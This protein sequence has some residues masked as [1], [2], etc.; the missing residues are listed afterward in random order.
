MRCRSDLHFGGIRMVAGTTSTVFV[1]EIHYDNAGGDV[2]EFIEIANTAGTDLTGWTLLLYN[3][4]NGLVYDTIALSGSDPFLTITFPANG[5][6]NGSPD[7]IAIV[8]ALGNVVQFLSYEGVMTAVDG[9]AAGLTSTDIGVAETTSTAVGFSLQLEGSGSTYGD[10]TWAAAAIAETPDAANTGQTIVPPFTPTTIFST[11]FDDFRGLGFA[12]EPVAGQLDSD[13]FRVLGMS[14]GNGSFGGTHTTGD[15]ARG[16]DV[17][18]GVSTGGVYA[19]EVGAASGDFNLGFQPGGSDVT[20]GS[21]DIVITNSGSDTNTFDISYN[22]EFNNNEGRANSLTLEYSTDGGATFVQVSA[23][24]F[25]TPEAADANGFTSV[26]RSGT[27]TLDTTISNGGSFILRFATDDVSGSGSRDEIAID[28]I[29][30]ITAAP[31]AAAS[32]GNF[33]INDVSLDEGDSG[34]T[35]FVF[36]VIRSGGSDGVATVDFS[37]SASSGSAVDASDFDGGVFPSGTVSFADGETAQ[38]ITIA[39]TGDIDIEADESFDVTLG[40]PTGGAT[41]ADDIGLGTI[42]NDDFPPPTPQGP[43]EVFINEIHYDNASGD[44]GEAIEIAGRA[45]TDLS[46]WQLVFYNG[47]GGVVYGTLDL[48]GV[49]PDQDD[50]YGTIGFSRS[51]LQNGSPDGLALVDPSGNVVQFLSYEGTMTATEGPAAGLTSDDIGVEEDG[52]T[53]AGFS[54]QLTGTGFIYDDFTWVS[55]REDNFGLV[56]TGQDF[57]PG[58]AAGTIIIQDA[59]VVEGDSG[60]TNL[61]FNVFRVGGTDGEVTVDFGTFFTG[62]FGAADPS[63]WAGQFGTSVTFAD[64]ESYQTVSIA[65]VGDTDGEPNET[66]EVRLSNPTGGAVIGDAVAIGTILND[67][68]VD[69][70][71]SEI[72]GAGH[73]SIWEGNEVTTTGVVTAVAANGFYMQDPLGDADAATSDA[74]FVFTGATPTV[75]VGDGLTVTGTVTEFLA[76][77]DSSNLTI[78]ELTNPVISVDS[79]GNPLPAAVVIGP[80]GISPPTEVIEDDGFTSFDPLTDGIDFWESLEGMLVTIQNPVAVDSTSGFGELWTAASDGEGNLVATNV[81]AEGLLVIDG[82]EGGLGVFNQGAGSDFNPERIQIDVAGELNGVEFIIPDVGPGARLNDVTGIVDYSFGNYEVRP[83]QAVTVAETSTSIAEAT[84]LVPGAQNQLSVASYNV[85]NFDINPDDGDD[86][87]GDGRLA[88][89]AYDIGVGLAAPDI[90]VLEEVQD[91]SGAIN[92]GTVS[93]TAT[94]QALAD[95]IFAETGIVYSVFDNP[96]VVDG[97]TGGQP[98][99]NIRVAFLYRDDRVDLDEASAFT[100]TD[101]E[102]GELDAAFAGSRAPLGANFTFNGETVTIIGSHFTSKIGSDNTFSGNQPPANAGALARAAQAAAIN[103]YIDGLLALD[104]DA[105]IALAGDF[106]EFHFEEPLEVLTG[107]LDFDGGSVSAG[108]S[109]VLENLTYLLDPSDRYSVLFQGNAQMLDHIL[110]TS[111]LAEGAAFDAVHLNT[112][113]GLP[114]SDH[115]PLLAI[116]NVGTQVVRGGRGGFDGNDGNDIIT[117]GT[118]SDVIN[119]NGGNDQ[120]NAGIGNDTVF[121]GSGR[122]QIEGGNGADEL[123]GEAGDDVIRGGNDADLINGG[124]DNDQLFGDNGDDQLFGGFGNDALSGGNGVDRLDGGFGLDTLFGG[125][126][127]DVFVLHADQTAADADVILDL[128]R[129]DSIEIENVDGREIELVASGNDTLITADGVLVARVIGVDPFT[130]EPA[131][132]GQTITVTTLSPTYGANGKPVTTETVVMR[133]DPEDKQAGAPEPLHELRG[134]STFD[135]VP[136]FDSAYGASE[137]ADSSSVAR[138]INSDGFDMLEAVIAPELDDFLAGLG[139][140]PGAGE[141][142]SAGV[143]PWMNGL[144]ANEVELV[145]FDAPAKPWLDDFSN[146]LEGLV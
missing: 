66:L 139:A 67:D 70:R 37:V 63:D 104:P 138:W 20:P 31:V 128:R 40:N 109:V 114:G 146:G 127:G 21:L 60:I 77:G 79:T 23:F 86:D 5:I 89:I 88:Q 137:F 1:N 62:G 10:F 91:D 46:G 69:L 107:A 81:S 58:P 38:T 96:F 59:E 30:V 105:L 97:Q 54:L 42:L 73:R 132:N 34:V 44:V 124:D 82:G 110:A 6:Q 125:A 41:I 122:D 121:G 3:G 115:D 84:A 61:V 24:D 129:G 140:A 55:P 26:A 64:G 100:I 99:G 113:V 53:P 50:G 93:A 141:P 12:P 76:G 101:P 98:G 35:N 56:N 13:V 65:I 87:V 130:V 9:A 135:P 18:G 136:A 74:I 49:I 111:A 32:P 145:M 126:G 75:A 19:F 116:F 78:T 134:V 120:I 143:E 80:D 15:F 90:V 25:T 33:S 106:N 2:G 92:D 131:I 39:V 94:L 123:Y 108:S 51:G 57:A 102:T 43:A 45:G 117:G 29:S 4:G 118:G 28:D 144:A 27:V 11:D 133:D 83:T 142:A 14:D 112:S 119:G 71:I 22:I 17:D 68:P 95:A 48:S 72:Q 16:S 85:L 52:G 7:A 103:S 8:D 36:T 47:N